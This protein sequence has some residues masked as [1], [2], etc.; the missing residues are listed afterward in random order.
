[1]DFDQLK[2]F[3]EVSKQKSFSKAAVKLLVTQPSIS[4]QISSLEKV[5]GVRLFERGGGKVTLTAAG[6]VFEPFAEDCLT[7]L[8]HI[9]MTI[10]DLERSPRGS[11][12]ISANDSTA[13]YVLPTFFAAFKKRYPRVSLNI[14]RAERSKT[15]ESVLNRE[16]D[17]GVVSLPVNDQRLHVELIHEDQ[18]VLVVP[19]EHPLVGCTN[20]TLKQVAQHSLL[21]PKQGQRREQLDQLFTQ[22]KLSPKIGMELDS[23]ELLKRLILAGMGIGFLPRINVLS[24]SR[25]G[26]VHIIP[27]EEIVIPR[28]LAIISRH[29]R[30]LTR[31]GQAFYTVTTR[32]VH[33]SIMVDRQPHTSHAQAASDPSGDFS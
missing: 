28:N 30:T 23:Y 2:T 13:L 26:L 12:L 33:P 22:K 1:V 17:F 9:S 5:V 19:P 29:D 15:I 6:R 8:N 32:L 7:R 16:A 27:S 20:V 24:E 3:L 14:M 18:W 4:A 10:A 31:A 25:A 21:V 11:L